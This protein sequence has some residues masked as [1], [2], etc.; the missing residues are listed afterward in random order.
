MYQR[1]AVIAT[2]T[3][4]AAAM[5]RKPFAIHWAASTVSPVRDGPAPCSRTN[6]AASANSR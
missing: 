4:V 5:V 6:P 1:P 3:T 2:A